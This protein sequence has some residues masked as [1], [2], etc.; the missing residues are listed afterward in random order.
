LNINSKKVDL[1]AFLSKNL[2]VPSKKVSNN[3]NRSIFSIR[4]LSDKKLIL[5]V[6]SLRKIELKIL[7]YLVG[8]SIKYEQV[9]PAHETIG[10]HA[11]RSRNTIIIITNRL[12]ELGLI[13]KARVDIFGVCRYRVSH[14]I[15]K[16]A[17]RL[18][19]IL[20]AIRRYRGDAE[21]KALIA[22][23]TKTMT[24]S[25]GDQFLGIMNQVR[26]NDSGPDPL[27]LITK[28]PVLSSMSAAISGD[29]D[30]LRKAEPFINQFLRS[31]P[32]KILHTLYTLSFNIFPSS[33]NNHSDDNIKEQT[34]KNRAPYV[35]SNIYNINN[36]QKRDE[37]SLHKQSETVYFTE[38]EE[39]PPFLED[40]SLKKIGISL[41]YDMYSDK[42]E[43]YREETT[44]G[45]QNRAY[46][47]GA[48]CTPFISPALKKAAQELGLNM[49]GQIKLSAFCDEALFHALRQIRT[50]VNIK[51]PFIVLFNE[52][53]RYSDQNRILINWAFSR[54]LAREHNMPEN[55]ET[56][57]LTIEEKR[58]IAQQTSVI[59]TPEP[60]SVST[61]RKHREPHPMFAMFIPK[62][63]RT[64]AC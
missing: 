58:T 37:I 34:I 16:L 64:D 62:D 11:K 57:Y 28:S 39:F 45:I 33:E 22:T 14:R 8:Q 38:K 60:E 5:L 51:D 9:Y 48:Y 55:P 42:K 20:P 63:L 3:P 41:L 10:R 44:N 7:N 1:Q 47:T 26:S 29:S 13:T 56:L 6:L 46:T 54:H 53:K 15:F 21:G 35:R 61:K 18:G 25:K 32:E 19:H 40:K 4:H 59:A 49:F 31:I 50:M 23:A 2:K 24:L 43:Q 36:L 52:A 17:S 30:L 12:C 27:S